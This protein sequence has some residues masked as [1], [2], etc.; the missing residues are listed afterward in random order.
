MKRK[1]K[2]DELFKPKQ[3]KVAKKTINPANH[4]NSN[5]EIQQTD[6]IVKVTMNLPNDLV[7]KL[8]HKAIDK[9]T[10]FTALVINAINN[11][12]IKKNS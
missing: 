1:S 2:I 9:N 11:C 4:I 8:K 3:E 6:S 5:T 12:L 10:T 7:R